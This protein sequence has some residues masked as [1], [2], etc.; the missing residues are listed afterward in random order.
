VTAQTVDSTD[1]IDAALLAILEEERSAH[2]RRTVKV[3]KDH[4]WVKDVLAGTANLH[5]GAACQHSGDWHRFSAASARLHAHTA[6]LMDGTGGE[7]KYSAAIRGPEREDWLKAL[8]EEWVR[9]LTTTSTLRFITKREVPA[10]ASVAYFNPRLKKKKNP[11]GSPKYRIRGTVG[12][13][14]INYPGD[15]AARTAADTTLKLFVNAGISEDAQMGTADITDFYLNC[16]L[17][18]VTTST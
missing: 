13:D 8:H 16:P 18:S 4:Q 1:E 5:S 14:K 12:G 6:I 10:G 2:R 15:K 17:P 11:D 3:V 7:L 9:L